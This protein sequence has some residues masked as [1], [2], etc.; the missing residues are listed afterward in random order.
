MANNS[1]SV[2]QEIESLQKEGGN[3]YQK[4][5]DNHHLTRTQAKNFLFPFVWGAK[6]SQ[7]KP[8]T[9]TEEEAKNLL[10]QWT[11]VD[12]LVKEMQERG[13]TVDTSKLRELKGGKD[14]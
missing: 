2:Q 6:P 8:I 14:S 7:I 9:A 10:K 11:S 4:F 1:Y 13:I 12:K 5:A 3:L